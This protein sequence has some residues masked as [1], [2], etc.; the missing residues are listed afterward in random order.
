[1]G[2]HFG[3]HSKLCWQAFLYHGRQPVGFAQRSISR[4]EQMHFDELSIPSG[5]KAHT[6]IIHS[7]LKAP[8][9]QLHSY[10]MPRIGIG[11]VQQPLEPSARL[12]AP[13]QRMFTATAIATR[14][15]TVA[16][17]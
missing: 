5:A 11:A 3:G 14:D 10:L 16:S 17:G 15:H 12:S 8:R 4:E 6:V 1:M 2:A 13:D 9:I 7:Q